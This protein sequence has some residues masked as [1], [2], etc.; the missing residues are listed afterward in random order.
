MKTNYLNDYR[1][2]YSSPEGKEYAKAEKIKNA[3]AKIGYVIILF[4][5]IT[6]FASCITT[7]RG[8]KKNKYGQ[9]TRVKCNKIDKSY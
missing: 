7:N 9:T 1:C 6:A 2:S 4:F 5:V 8:I 3:I